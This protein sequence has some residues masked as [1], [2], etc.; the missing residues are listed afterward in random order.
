MSNN[1]GDEY[2]NDVTDV[3]KVKLILENANKTLY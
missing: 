3:E 2:S 1:Y